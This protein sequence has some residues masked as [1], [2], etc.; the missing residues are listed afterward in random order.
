MAADG[1]LECSIVCVC[2]LLPEFMSCPA[3]AWPTCLLRCCRSNVGDLAKL[4]ADVIDLL[5]LVLQ[6]PLPA[7][8]AAVVTIHDLLDAH[9]QVRYPNDILSEISQVQPAQALLAQAVR[10]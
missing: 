5:T 9:L 6:A 4:R 10:G 8:A 3:P 7:A 1:L 2:A